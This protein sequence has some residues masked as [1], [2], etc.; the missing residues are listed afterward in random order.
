[1]T[2]NLRNDIKPISY[3]KTNAADMM[4]Y[5]TDNRSPIIITQN[6]EAKAALVDIESYQEMQDA[7]SLLKIIRLAERDVENGRVKPA[8]QVMS[9]IKRKYGIND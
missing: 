4:K 2:I 1:M 7:F 9:E 6:G 8:N 3:I 5:I